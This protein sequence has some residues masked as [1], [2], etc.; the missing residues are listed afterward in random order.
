MSWYDRPNNKVTFLVDTEAWTSDDY[1][2]MMEQAAVNTAELFLLR[3]TYIM[4]PLA[5]RGALTP[6][7]VEK[8]LVAMRNAGMFTIS[9]PD[10]T[11]GTEG[12]GASIDLNELLGNTFSAGAAT[13]AQR[14]RKKLEDHLKFIATFLAN[15]TWRPEAHDRFVT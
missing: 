14:N 12:V 9:L 11:P 1:E 2:A 6:G 8:A 10:T 13:R 7:L 5:E 4:Q 15:L 3:N